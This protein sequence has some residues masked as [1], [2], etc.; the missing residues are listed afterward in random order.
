[1]NPT[2]NPGLAGFYQEFMVALHAGLG[3]K[4]YTVLTLSFIGRLT[5]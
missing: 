2:G 5:E 3:V 4:E 1:M